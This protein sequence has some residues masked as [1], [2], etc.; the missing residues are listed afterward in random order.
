M[1]SLVISLCMLLFVGVTAMAQESGE[2]VVVNTTCGKV[3]GIMQEGTM[4]FLGIPYAKVERFMPP[5]PVDKWEGVRACDHWGPQTMQPT[6]GRQ[7]RED[8]MSEKNCCVL[9]V[10]TTE[11]RLQIMLKAQS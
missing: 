5:L 8:E 2:T 4:G 6:G 9:N 7:L 11:Y 10:W 1:K 3:S